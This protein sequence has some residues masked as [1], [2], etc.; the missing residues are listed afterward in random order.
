MKTY[1]QKYLTYSGWDVEFDT[2][3]GRIGGSVLLTIILLP[4]RVLI[5]RLLKK[6]DQNHVCD[7]FD[8]LEKILKKNREICIGQSG[9]WWF[10]TTML[11]D[12]GTEMGDFRRLERS[13]FSIKGYEHEEF[14]RTCVF[15]T[16]PY[17]SWQK[18]HIEEVHT[19]I[20]RILPKKSSF[21]GLTQ[22]DIDL[23]CSHI[24]SYSRA[25]LD[26]ATPFEVAP[27]GFSDKLTRALGQ[28]RIDPDDV[29]LTPRLLDY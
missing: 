1:D 23:V 19:L 5:A 17:S 26:G 14:A 7:E 15:Y 3:I 16:D 12:R 18:P 22:K 13:L 9:I 24:N 4:S 11:T 27:A 25:A 28:K 2:V 10:F 8:R 6:K 29:N 21:D 20:R